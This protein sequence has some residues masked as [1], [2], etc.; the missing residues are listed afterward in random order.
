MLVVDTGCEFQQC[1][2]VVGEFNSRRASDQTFGLF[3]GRFEQW[4]AGHVNDVRNTPDV[5]FL[6]APFGSVADTVKHGLFRAKALSGHF[7]DASNGKEGN[8]IC[9]RK[10]ECLGDAKFIDSLL[11]KLPPNACRQVA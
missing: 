7:A 6:K 4:R 1:N 10:I 11:M 8:Y 2:Q 5:T 9:H 3:S